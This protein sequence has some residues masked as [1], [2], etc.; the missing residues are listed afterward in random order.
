M[1][2]CESASCTDT[3]LLGIAQSQE[4]GMVGLKKI[5]SHSGRHP[6]LCLEVTVICS[7]TMYQETNKI[8]CFPCELLCQLVFGLKYN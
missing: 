5:M 1:K 2:V 8:C 7:V 3:Q 6:N 4:F